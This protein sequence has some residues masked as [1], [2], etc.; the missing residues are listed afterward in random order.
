MHSRGRC[1]ASYPKPASRTCT[2]H[3]STK[4]ATSIRPTSTSASPDPREAATTTSQRVRTTWTS[5]EHAVWF[6]HRDIVWDAP[7]R[8]RGGDLLQG[9]LTLAF[10]GVRIV[11][12]YG[13]D[14]MVASVREV[15]TRPLHASAVLD[16]LIEALR[17][18]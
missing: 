6:E 10:D 16:A 1:G 5:R 7:H 11:A 15:G 9:T 4:T 14:A 3:G 12:S 13:A 18:P 2:K 8:P 17:T